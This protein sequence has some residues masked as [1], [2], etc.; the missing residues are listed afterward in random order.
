[1]TNHLFTLF[2]SHSRFTSFL[3]YFVAIPMNIKNANNPM[4]IPHAT[5][6]CMY[7]SKNI[8]SIPALRK[9][10]NPKGNSAIT[11]AGYFLICE[12]VINGINAAVPA[13]TPPAAL[14]KI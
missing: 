11:T 6:S 4:T 7:V 10:P 8:V 14:N 2:T 1:M 3:A 5:E 9:C 12:N 13:K